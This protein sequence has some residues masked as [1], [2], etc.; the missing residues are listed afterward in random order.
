M[1]GL[2]PSTLRI[3][4]SS[5]KL[6]KPFYTTLDNISGRVVFAPHTPVEVHDVLI[7]FVGTAATWMDPSTPGTPR[8]KAIFEV[9]D[10]PFQLFCNC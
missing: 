7:D 10:L 2:A 4:L 1:L 6:D 3:D 9:I 5:S 8:K